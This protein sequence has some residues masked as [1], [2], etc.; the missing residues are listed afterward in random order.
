MTQTIEEKIADIA[1]QQKAE[2]WER[3]Q[4]AAKAHEHEAEHRRAERFRT[5]RVAQ[6]QHQLKDIPN[7]KK[8]AEAHAAEAEELAGMWSNEIDNSAQRYALRVNSER[9]SGRPIRLDLASPEAMAYFFRGIIKKSLRQLALTANQRS[10][11]VPLLDPESLA[12]ELRE[13]EIRLR[14]ELSEL[15]VQS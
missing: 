13:E 2:Q 9:Q 15:Q 1:S 12:A 11:G 10:I 14:A 4:Q 7:R 5:Q 3:R 6:L 8:L